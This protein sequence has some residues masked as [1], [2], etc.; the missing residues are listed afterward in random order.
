MKDIYEKNPVRVEAFQITE[1]IYNELT[2]LADGLDFDSA[3]C[4]ESLPIWL[5]KAHEDCPDGID[6]IGYFGSG[7]VIFSSKKRALFIVTLEGQIR[8]QPRDWIIKG[9]TGELYPCKPD[10]F[11]LTY[12][13]VSPL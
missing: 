3:D 5:Q 1:K 11:E 7:W 13:K 2:E 9:V 8:V 10:I 4:W 12:S 6:T